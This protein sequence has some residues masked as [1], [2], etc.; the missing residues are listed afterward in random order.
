MLT[1]F[2][3]Q[4]G[5]T[6]VPIDAN[7]E[8]FDDLLE[9][10][11]LAELADRLERRLTKLEQRRSLK[12]EEQLAYAALW[13]SRGD[14]HVI[15][16]EITAAKDTLRKG[17]RFFDAES[18]ARATATIDAALRVISA[19]Y[20]PLSLDFTA[21]RTPLALTT[22][23]EIARDAASERD[24][25]DGYV[26]KKLIPRLRAERPDVIGLSVAFPGQLQPAYAF[27]L[28]LKAALPE[29]H[30]TVGGPAMTQLL[31]RLK[32][33]ELSR[34]LGPFDSA[35]V[36]EGEHTLLRLLQARAGGQGLAGIANVVWRRGD[37]TAAYDPGH[38][39]EDLKQLP[40]PD[41]D[42]LPLDRYLSPQLILP[43][44]PTRGC[45]WGKCTFCHYGLAEVGT[46]AYRERAVP[47]M[48]EHLAALKERYAT[49]FFYLSQDSVAPK[50]LLR[51]AEGL[52]SAGLRIRWATDV[53]PERYLHAERAKTLASSGA[54]ACALGVESAAPRVL[55]LIDKGAPVEAVRDVI[56]NLAQ[57]GVAAEAMCFT[58]FPTETYREAMATLRFLEELRE[59]VALFIVGEFDLTHG[60]LVAQKPA[61][62]GLREVYTLDGDQL[63]TGLFYEEARPGKRP[64][65]QER[66]DE[67][68]GRLSQGWRLR[69]YPW[70]GAVSTAHTI[71]YYARF[72]PAVF[73]EL[74]AQS[75]PQ[76]PPA[77]RPGTFTQVRV[78]LARFDLRKA[79]AAR[80]REAAIWH[81]LVRE[82]RHV[83]RAAYEELIAAQP[84]LR[85]ER[86]PLRYDYAAGTT[87]PAK[88]TGRRPSHAPNAT[89]KTAPS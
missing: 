67:A 18:Y 5:V 54:V 75:R 32:G 79:E 83:S 19:A 30:L 16:G 72:G 29:A 6:V 14:A 60:A 65:E 76:K 59:Q 13:R 35:V 51:L 12:H 28:K 47:Q 38:G 82:R 7:I 9:P 36:F 84:A 40:A 78:G 58:D 62:F 37:G 33:A 74:S 42:G 53:K 63:R 8:A 61:D 25:F 77:A 50:T 45:Y 15:P 73:R 89:A 48:L 34:A 44:D 39:M 3:R 21:Y 52:L 17:Q 27:A 88:T 22:P 85:P 11:P 69:S 68:L 10:Q 26:W 57:A 41:F 49:D 43:Y 4:H 66:L 80:G 23:Q 56:T 64:D 70:A 46:A 31:I 86:S 81:E 24:P 71:L 55:K 87:P 1:G 20:T 2:L